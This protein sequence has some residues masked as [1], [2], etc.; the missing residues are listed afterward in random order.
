MRPWCPVKVPYTETPV[1]SG[2]VHHPRPRDAAQQ[3]AN[4]KLGCNGIGAFRSRDSV[5]CPVIPNKT[6][7]W[8]HPSR[9]ARVTDTRQPADA[10]VLRGDV[11][12]A[13]AILCYG[14]EKAHFGSG[15]CLF[16]RQICACDTDV[17][18]PGWPGCASSAPSSEQDWIH[19]LRCF[20]SCDASQLDTWARAKGRR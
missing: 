11:T 9:Y 13:P 12:F 14:V 2:G 16:R 1:S 20:A 4:R 19:P 10:N 6:R 15:M 8:L 5:L 7:M 18:S 3:P 17:L